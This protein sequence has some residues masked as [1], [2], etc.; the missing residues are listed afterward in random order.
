VSINN[1]LELFTEEV[2]HEE[3]IKRV[4]LLLSEEQLCSEQKVQEVS[5]V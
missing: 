3:N 1:I 2:L 5:N 4:S